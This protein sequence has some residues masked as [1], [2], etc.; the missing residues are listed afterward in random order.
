VGTPKLSHRMFGSKDP[1]AEYRY[2]HIDIQF[3]H[4]IQYIYVCIYIYNVRIMCISC[5]YRMYCKYKEYV[6]TYRYIY[7]YIQC[8][9]VYSV[10]VYL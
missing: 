6:Y 7:T 2:R 3:T 8:I 4:Y 1:E 10:H 9:Y 5:I